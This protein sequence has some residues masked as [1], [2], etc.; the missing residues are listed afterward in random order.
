MPEFMG[1]TGFVWWQGVVED[2]HD[3]LQLGRCR[4]RILGWHPQARASVSISDLPW[5]YPLSPITSAAM[6]GI[7][8]APVGP[9][10]GTWVMGFFRDGENAQEPVMLGTLGGIPE[11]EPCLRGLGFFDPNGV[12][13]L[14]GSNPVQDAIDK[15]T[16]IE[17]KVTG[18]LPSVAAIGVLLGVDRKILDQALDI[19]SGVQGQI[20]TVSSVTSGIETQ[21]STAVGNAV[22]AATG[23]DATPEQ[24]E[25]ATKNIVANSK[26][27]ITAAAAGIL[28]GTGLPEVAAIESIVSGSQADI[29][30]AALGVISNIEGLEGFS[31]DITTDVKGAVE[32]AIADALGEFSIVGKGIEREPA[33][34]IDAAKALQ[35]EAVAAA[36]ET[37]SNVLDGLAD[38][39]PGGIPGGIP[40]IP[41]DVAAAIDDAAAAAGEAAASAA[42][43]AG[44]SVAEAAA[45]GEAA[46]SE[47][48][49]A[50]AGG[51][52]VNSLSGIASGTISFEG[53][54]FSTPGLREPDT[55]RL[56]RTDG[57]V[58]LGKISEEHPVVSQKTNV[59]NIPGFLGVPIE[60]IASNPNAPLDKD[61]RQIATAN[62]FVTWFEPPTCAPFTEYPFNHVYESESGHIQEFD[63]T[64]GFERIHTFHKSGTFDEVHPDGSRMTKV[65]GNNYEIILK[66][67]NLLVKGDLNITVDGQARI[68]IQ[69]TFD[70]EVDD[71]TMQV[72]IRK[73]NVNVQV[74]NG[75][76]NVFV[77]GDLT[78]EVQGNRKDTVLGGY[79]LDVKGTISI[80]AGGSVFIRGASIF[81]N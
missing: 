76:A 23:V 44:A 3:P 68:K 59:L 62:S 51:N 7:G 75:D 79:V 5:A 41:K 42:A 34:V 46:V 37:V 2:R 54:K 70:I 33:A 64:P 6:N 69:K 31:G 57:E 4:V 73:G 26:S 74:E 60:S 39:I 77:K 30:A 72:V 9:V 55:S 35:A 80:Q 71:G 24:I 52:L 48:I 38:V 81:L 20:E 32:G 17:S 43:A 56:A 58:I 14:P 45:A 12:Y 21:I 78:T 10:E 40:G 50:A 67:D 22:T 1:T 27:Q 61:L 29:E 25:A 36:S 49:A 11:E 65:V 13:P 8:H 18:A 47:A 53:L 15:V 16:G 63:D 28:S 66:D 19:S